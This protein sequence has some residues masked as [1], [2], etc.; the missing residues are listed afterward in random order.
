MR[1]LINNEE[2]VCSNELEINEEMLTTSST[3]LNNCYPKS[4]EL[5]K[6]YISRFY[7]PKD[8]SKCLIYDNSDN[9]IFSGV[10]KNT[11]EISLNPREPHF[12]N[13][14]VLDF[15]TFLSEG[16]ILDFVIS[17][18][19]IEE[20]IEMVTTAISSYG[21]VL[22]DIDIL[23]GDDVIGAYSTANKTAYDV[24]QYLAEIS[25]SKWTTRLVD[26]NTIA[27]DFYD[28]TLMPT[29]DDLEYTTEYFEDNNIES[30]EF[31]YGTYDYRNKQVITSSQVYGSI[32]YTETILAN[33]FSRTFDTTTTIGEVKSI[34]VEGVAK[35]FGTNDEKELGFDYNFYYTPGSTQFESNENEPV[36]TSNDEITITYTPLLI[37][38]EI[39]YN[40]DEVDRVSTQIGRN[41][42]VSRYE[43]R[44]DVLSSAELNKIAQTYIKYKGEA[45]IKLTVKTWNI[46]LYDVGQVV[47]FNAPI[48][49]LKKEYMVKRKV[50]QTYNTNE[51]QE[52]FCEY[53]LTSS[54]NSEREVNYFDN[55][56]NK[57]QG[58]ISTGQFITRNVDIENT[59]LI[60]FNNLSYEEID[61]GNVL[62]SVLNSPLSN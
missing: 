37:G 47:Y 59:A 35:T 39:V 22:G 6:D 31:S 11:A 7:F 18:K 52:M 3:I 20:A 28:P 4:W 61:V 12:A 62:N 23:N 25:N 5:D 24:Y 30:I 45:E 1:I 57:A 46:D 49:E 56:R 58:N 19:T 27:V 17:E 60:I 13:L 44:N 51:N 38:R 8:Y 10:I 29:A 36:Y 50:I 21:V 32:D 55:Q 33:G 42:I 43:E 53:T 48:D 2:V 54:F 16:D 14:Q 26:E 15:K 41:G 9:L 40:N 34:Y